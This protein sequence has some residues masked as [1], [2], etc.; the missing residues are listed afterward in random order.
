M[1]SSCTH[2]I[3][4]LLVRAWTPFFARYGAVLESQAHAIPRVLAGRN[5][6]LCAPTASGKTEAIV[7]PT[8]EMAA[9]SNWGPMSVLYVTPTRALANDTLLRIEGPLSDMGISAALKHGDKPSFDP[10]H[11]PHWLI[12]TPESLDSLL[13]RHSASLRDVRTVILDEL[14]LLD[15]TYRGDQLRVLLRRLSS[16]SRSGGLRSHALSATMGKPDQVAARYVSDYEIVQVKGQRKICPFLV[17]DLAEMRELARTHRWRKALYFCNR[18]ESV[19]ETAAAIKPLWAPYPVVAHHGSLDRRER[20]SAESVMK[21]QRVA[22]CV[23]TS[24]LEVGIDIG[25]IDVVVLVELPHSI[26]SF[27]QRVGRGCRRADIVNLVVQAL[28]ADEEQVINAMIKAAED[29]LL[30]TPVYKPDLSVAIQ[31]TF[32]LL[33]QYP[34]GM[35]QSDLSEYMEPIVGEPTLELI[36][37]HLEDDAW[38]TRARERW[39]ATRKTMNL[40]VRGTLHSNVPDQ[41]QYRVVNVSSHVPVGRIGDIFDHVFVLSRTA[42]EVVRVERA[43]V[44]VRPYKGQAHSAFFTPTRTKGRFTPLLPAEMRQ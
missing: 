34:S 14:H 40:G 39:Y 18:R 11:A 36:L 23:C 4:R 31:Q 27:L 9:A 1:G 3:R 5:I 8:A 32:S 37:K 22:A 10:K 2:D 24:T 26:S 19:E 30:D 42:W 25:D 28:T 41:G 13:C 44:Y 33:F 16:Q 43:T 17:R 15:N 6:V 29:G 20:L 38:I 7:A 35:S 21:E 12:T